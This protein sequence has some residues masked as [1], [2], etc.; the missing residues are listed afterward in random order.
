MSS[1]PPPNTPSMEHQESATTTNSRP[2]SPRGDITSRLLTELGHGE[3]SST[4]TTVESISPLLQQL[5]GT[6]KALQDKVESIDNALARPVHN[7]QTPHANIPLPLP[8][9]SLS[10][11]SVSLSTPPGPSH[12]QA[13]SRAPFEGDIAKFK[14]TITYEGTSDLEPF[15]FALNQS[16]RKY[17]LTSDE[18]KLI[19]LGDSLRGDGGHVKSIILLQRQ[20]LGWK[21]NLRTL[22][23]IGN[24]SKS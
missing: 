24:T 22:A 1:L 15:L 6:V 23:D 16:I 18:N 3:R 11:Q 8:P 19:A 2:P 20:S 5:A 13:D 17:R 4:V 7:T 9:P 21:T 10:T 14:A 12:S